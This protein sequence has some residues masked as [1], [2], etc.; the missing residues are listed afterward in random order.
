V[1]GQLSCPCFLFPIA[2]FIPYTTDKEDLPA[3]GS[4]QVH[5]AVLFAV[6]FAN[7][8]YMV[9]GFCAGCCILK[10]SI[11]TSGKLADYIT[12]FFFF[13]QRKL[14]KVDFLESLLS[15]RSLVHL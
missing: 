5:L 4:Q 8:F 9:L 2:R 10:I 14:L 11:G 15:T 6:L 3:V 12:G 13:L 7:L 1:D